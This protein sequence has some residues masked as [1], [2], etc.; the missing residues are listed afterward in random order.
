MDKTM[1]ELRLIRGL[2]VREASKKSNISVSRIKRWEST[3]CGRA[4]LYDVCKLLH[5]YRYNIDHV[6]FNRVPTQKE[7]LESILAGASIVMAS[8]EIQIDMDRV[9]CLMGQE[10]FE[11]SELQAVLDQDKTKRPA[12]SSSV[13]V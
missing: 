4:D 8:G 2:T 1:K 12:V 9:I 7:V 6:D 5:V 11:T 3:G 13:S 10:G